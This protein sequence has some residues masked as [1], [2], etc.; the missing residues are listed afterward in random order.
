MIK[1]RY[2]KLAHSD[3][4]LIACRSAW[5]KTAVPAAPASRNATRKSAADAIGDFGTRRL[6]DVAR[7]AETHGICE[8]CG[9]FQLGSAPAEGP[10]DPARSGSETACAS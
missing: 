6:P 2:T 10:A 9:L 8:D 3:G 1:D 5:K 7:G 4:C